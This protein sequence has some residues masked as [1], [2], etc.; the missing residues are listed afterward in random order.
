MTIG[1]N[2]NNFRKPT[3]PMEGKPSNGG[4][5][6]NWMCTVEGRAVKRAAQVRMEQCEPNVCTTGKFRVK[7][8][9]Q[10]IDYRMS[11]LEEFQQLHK[12]CHYAWPD[13]VSRWYAIGQRGHKGF[14]KNEA[15]SG[16][17]F[18][19]SMEHYNNCPA[20]RETSVVK[21]A[22][23]LLSFKPLRYPK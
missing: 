16:E 15:P 22:D 12:Q 4:R 3:K 8:V 17:R 11:V 9:G 2:G 13:A 5:K 18:T 21:L 6:I 10:F 7:D 20:L 14:Y 19:W 23:K 1:H